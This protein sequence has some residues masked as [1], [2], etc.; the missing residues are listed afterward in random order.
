MTHSEALVAAARPF[1]RNLDKARKRAR[2]YP[3][4][5]PTVS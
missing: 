2:I 3:P 5:A 4:A 1:L